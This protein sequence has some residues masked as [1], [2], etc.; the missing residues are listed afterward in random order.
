MKLINLHQTGAIAIAR[1]MFN[2]AALFGWDLLVR[3]AAFVGVA[4]GAMAIHMFVVY[5][6]VIWI[7]GG[8]SPFGFFKAVREPMVVA[9]STAS[10]NASLPVSL[11]AAEHE[12][13]LPRKIARF[14]ADRRPPQTRTAR[15]CSRG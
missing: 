1:L 7:L 4:V 12:L 9:F 11:K 10:S 6:L 2:L 8:R 15:P 3:L 13:K 14:C 5:P